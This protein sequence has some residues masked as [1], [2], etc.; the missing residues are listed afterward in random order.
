VAQAPPEGGLVA[1]LAGKSQDF[2]RTS[3]VR[4]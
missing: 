4:Y 2:R 3:T 1:W